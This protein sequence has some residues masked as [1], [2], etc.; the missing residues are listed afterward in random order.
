MDLKKGI[1]CIILWISASGPY[2]ASCENVV[3]LTDLQEIIENQ[4]KPIED[5][6]QVIEN[7]ETLNGELNTTVE[8]LKN[9]EKEYF[10]KHILF[11]NRFL[12]YRT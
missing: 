11:L 5:Q 4:T 6:R 2:A 9:G 1:V 10:F 3:R 12:Q 8:Q 7:Q